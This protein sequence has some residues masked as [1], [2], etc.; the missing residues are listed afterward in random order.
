MNN[1]EQK[2]NLS[3]TIGFIALVLSIIALV[4]GGF[5]QEPVTGPDGFYLEQANEAGI[6]RSTFQTCLED[7]TIEERI[8]QEAQEAGSIGGQGTP[9]NVIAFPDG[10]MIPVPGAYPYEVFADVIDRGLA[11][12]LTD[13]ELEGALNINQITDFD[14][15]VDYYKGDA[16]AEVTIFEWSDYEC[17]YCARVHGELQRVVDNYPNVNW[18]Y[19]NLPLS[20]HQQAIPAA[21]AALCIGREEGNEAFWSFTDT[22]F[23]DQSVLK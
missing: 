8:N 3:L 11:G 5:Q 14:P 19:R 12:E 21:K 17:P 18:V 20:F 7:P 2:A 4:G 9:F 1:I 22:L 15:E 16:D 6:R 10:T 13:E 23:S